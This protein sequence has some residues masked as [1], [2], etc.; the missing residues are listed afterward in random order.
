MP[1]RP[2]TAL[3]CLLAVLLWAASAFGQDVEQPFGFR[4]TEWNQTLEDVALEAEKPDLT[5]QRSQELRERLFELKDD[6]EAAGADARTPLAALQSRLDALGPVPAEGAPPEAPDIAAQR[7]S[8][9]QQIA[10]IQGRVQQTEL[11]LARIAELNAELVSFARETTIQQL[12][13]LY[14]FPLNP[15]NV[16]VAVPEFFRHLGALARAPAEWWRQLPPAQQDVAWE[17]LGSRLLI[18]A[19]LAIAVGWMLRRYLLRR[20][21]RDP[22]IAEPSYTRRL[23]AAV[24]EGVANGLMPAFLFGAVLYRVTQ[25]S[26]YLTGLTQDMVAAFCGVMIFFFLTRAFA[27]AGLAP[28]LPAWRIEDIP[29]DKARQIYRLV[30]TLAAILAVDLFFLVSTEGLGISLELESLYE[31]VTNTIEAALVIALMRVRLWQSEPEAEETD[32][33]E[34]TSTTISRF[35]GFVRVAVILVAAASIVASFLGY[36]SLS[37]YLTKNLVISAVIIGGLYLIRGL[38]RE[39]IGALLRSSFIQVQ[40]ALKHRTR[41]V[42]KFWARAL[43]DLVI[44]VIAILLILPGWGVPS[45][46]VLRWSGETLKGVTIGNVTISITDLVAALVVFIVTVVITRML[47]RVLSDQVLPQTSLDTGVRHSLSAGIGYIGVILAAALA[48]STVGLDLSNLALIAGALS[49]GIGFGL[50]TVVNNFVSGLI[51]LVERP[52]KVGDWVVVS[53]HEGYVKRINVRATELE[54]FQ[55]ASVIIP[56]SELVA[57]AVINWTHKNKLGRVEV[58]VGVAYG[59]DVDKVMKIL[60]DCLRAHDRVLDWPE[61]YVLFRG[62]GDSSLDFEARGFLSDVE[63]VITV[64]SELRVAINRAFLAED[65]E[66]PFPQ[67]DL[68]LKD[69]DRLANAIEG[70]R[71]EKRQDGG[72]AVRGGVVSG[73]PPEVKRRRQTASEVETDGPDGEGDS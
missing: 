68:H 33:D 7:E 6:V 36:A 39:L 15:A 22:A 71:T 63:Y 43:L 57:T 17:R 29:P 18:M 5:S 9:N 31:L 35:W 14:P 16:T 12:L 38:F 61:P 3:P 62:F 34:K 41:N 11:T 46:E 51:L 56:N 67:R 52:I 55:R 66:I 30:T 28:Y 53:G 59:S 27:R 48:I 26:S 58:P 13:T 73:T 25:E 32:P 8:L 65:I 37:G 64:S 1:L 69:I 49:V 47:Q 21:G 70:S 40:L 50:Q 20:F 42:V 72:D 4:L 44:A 45:A 24:V 23:G 54:T 19:L 2:R 60:E 10:E